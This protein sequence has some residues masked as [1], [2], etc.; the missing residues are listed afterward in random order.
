MVRLLERTIIININSENQ[1]KTNI[2]KN[3]SFQKI[4]YLDVIHNS[5]NNNFN[6][7]NLNDTKN[8]NSN[9]MN[10]KNDQNIINSKILKR[11]ISFYRNKN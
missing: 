11:I 2:Y 1:M 9:N 8:H 10:N 6:I 3:R 7:R 5:K 4:D